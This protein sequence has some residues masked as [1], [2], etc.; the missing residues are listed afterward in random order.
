MKRKPR[1]FRHVEHGRRMAVL[2]ILLRLSV[3]LVMIAQF[4]NRNYENVFLCLLTL[5]LFTLPALI[6][7][8]LRIDLPDTL[9]VIIL[10]F[11]YAAEILGEIEAYYVNL[12]FWDTM[13]H[14]LNGFLCAAIGFSLV[15]LLNRTERVA[16][17]LSPFFMAVVAFCFSMTVGVL[18]EFFERF[19][20]SVLLFDMQKDHIVHTIAS[21]SLDPTQSNEVI[22]VRDIADVILV[23]GDGSQQAL[24]LGGYLDLG[25]YDTMKDLFVNFIGAVVFSIIGYFFVKSRGKGRFARRF[26]P[27]VLMDGEETPSESSSNS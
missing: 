16:L 3:I 22:I 25:I 12:P 4:F 7:R 23:H 18:W 14:T 15:A 5:V 19:M 9:E 11:I 21:V 24:G 17:N 26:I 13:L 8:Q 20:D 6:E 10:L 27:R 2:Y 1:G